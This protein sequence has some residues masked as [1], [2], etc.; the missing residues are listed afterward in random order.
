MWRPPA[1]LVTLY[2][3]VSYFA[4]L[5][6]ELSIVVVISLAFVVGLAVFVIGVIFI[7][8]QVKSSALS[9][10]VQD[11]CPETEP[12]TLFH[13]HHGS[14]LQT[15]RILCEQISPGRTCTAKIEEQQKSISVDPCKYSLSHHYRVCYPCIKI[16]LLYA[17]YLKRAT[18]CA[19]CSGAATLLRRPC[20]AQRSSGYQLLPFPQSITFPR[21]SRQ[22]LQLADADALTPR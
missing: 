1:L 3:A 15:E 13:P 6:T 14:K 19:A 20:R 8:R 16:W 5:L 21:S 17:C 10:Y 4:V 11:R 12:P 9:K 7:Q 22:P 2:S 18:S